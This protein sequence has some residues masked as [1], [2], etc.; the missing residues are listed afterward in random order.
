MNADS[1][2]VNFENLNVSLGIVS[3]NL[4]DKKPLIFK[5]LRN[6]A[7]GM[8]HSF[9]PGFGNSLAKAIQSSCSAYPFFEPV[10]I[11]IDKHITK[12]VIDGGFVANNPSL[13]ALVD[14]KESLKISENRIKFISIGTGN[15]PES[16]PF[17]SY[18]QGLFL[19]PNLEMISMQ[20]SSNSNAIEVLF[21]L[22]SKNIH[23]L[24]INDTFNQPELSTS[25][26][27]SDTKKLNVLF[28][29]GKD[30]FASSEKEFRAILEL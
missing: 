18:P 4:S 7:H 3:T 10:D 12:K 25:L 26:F 6:Q 2:N 11:E 21:K 13:Y 8:K 9:V 15:Y 22:M 5:S 19:Y 14:L 27:E 17:Y 24:R 16:Y 29:K 20:F 28:G 30:S 1:I 23:S